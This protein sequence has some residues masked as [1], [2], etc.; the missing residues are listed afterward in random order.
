MLGKDR[1]HTRE[2]LGL[3]WRSVGLRIVEGSLLG[4]CDG[5]VDFDWPS[6]VRWQAALSGGRDGE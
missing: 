3:L 6:S 4:K 2:A 5:F 1:S